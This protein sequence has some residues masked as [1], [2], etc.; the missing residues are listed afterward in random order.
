MQNVQI[1]FTVPLHHDQTLR[2]RTSEGDVRVTVKTPMPPVS[3]VE[4][5]K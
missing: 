3:P 2:K 1:G 5:H 4:Q